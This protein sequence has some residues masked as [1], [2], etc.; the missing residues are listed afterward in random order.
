MNLRPTFRNLFRVAGLFAAAYALGCAQL[1][2]LPNQRSPERVEQVK[3]GQRATANAA[4]WGF[5]ET[6][7]TDALQSAINSGARRVVV[8][9][10]GKDWVIRPIYLQS[11][12]EIVFERGV[13]ITAR[14]GYFKNLGDC[15][16]RAVGKSNIRLTGYGAILRMQKADYTT[17]DYQKSEWR[18][19]LS[20][21]GCS[22]VTICGLTIRDTGGDGIYLGRDRAGSPHC[23]NIVIRDVLCDNNHRQGIS[24]I[25]AV[26]LLIEK[27]AFNN[28]SGTAPQEGIDFEPNHPDESLADCVVRNCRFENN[29]S[30]GIGLYLRNLSRQSH[31]LSV[32]IEN[33]HV[34]SPYGGGLRLGA[35]K[36]DGPDGVI[37]IRNCVFADCGGRGLTVT[38][39]SAARG[40]LVFDRCVWKNVSLQEARD[41]QRVAASAPLVLH[42]SKTALTQAYGCIEFRDCRVEDNFDRPI[43]TARFPRGD[44]LMRDIH[45]TIF[46]INPHGVRTHWDDFTE[47]VNLKMISASAPMP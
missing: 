24:V 27:S 39:K 45:G 8:P 37:E 19:G 16:F 13:V 43:L 20:L 47:N 2:V 42:F 31:P 28:T 12:Q 9:N 30:T 7:A 40:R 35:W 46:A 38:D 23:R 1:S 41:P 26:N 11:D 17:A 4:W 15:L 22:D 18:H 29:R 10:M 44:Y 32:R 25:S 14:K 21:L 3:A 6:D 5:D 34:S 36:D 33:C